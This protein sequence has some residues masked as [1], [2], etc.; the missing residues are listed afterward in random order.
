MNNPVTTCWVVANVMHP[1]IFYFFVS[2]YSNHWP[3]FQDINVESIA[4]L[5]L[6]IPTSLVLSLPSLAGGVYWC[7]WL[8]KLHM[9][10]S[11]KFLVW[12]ISMPLLTLTNH[13]LFE[14]VLLQSPSFF[15]FSETMMIT[16]P[17]TSA[18]IASSLIQNGAF[19]KYFSE[20]DEIRDSMRESMTLEK[21]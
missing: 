13:Y 1:F 12:L 9:C 11:N 16:I 15:T 3:L 20:H 14:L 18:A 10:W 8:R 5:F 4:A 2:L 7:K 17:A 21:R 6:L 19:R